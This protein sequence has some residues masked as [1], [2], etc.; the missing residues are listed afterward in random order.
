MIRKVLVIDDEEAITIIVKASLQVTAGWQVVTT[1]SAM[2]GI[3]IAQTEQPDAILLD[4]SMPKLDGTEVFK[5]LQAD[6][7]TRNIP[8][9][10]LTAKARASD[11][12]ALTALGAAGIILKPFD[13]EAIADNIREIVGWCDDN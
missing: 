7:E 2:D 12:Q 3:Q 9:I 5:A 8:V 1:S 10:F 11:Q 4:V 6:E 13:P